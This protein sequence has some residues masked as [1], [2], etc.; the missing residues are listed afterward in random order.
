M[1]KYC[2]IKLIS[3]ILRHA[4]PDGEG[5]V[6]INMFENDLREITLI[7]KDEGIGL[8]PGLVP[9]E[10]DTTGLSLVYML[11]EG[12]LEGTVDFNVDKGTI[13]TIKSKRIE[14]KKRF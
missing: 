7:V 13:V 10:A 5:N 2:I 12:Q 3:N 9:S 11:E 14:D 8:S 4:H 6:Y 1:N